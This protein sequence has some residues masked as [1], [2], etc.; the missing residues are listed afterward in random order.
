MVAHYPGTTVSLTT[1]RF[2]FKR[3]F[4]GRFATGSLQSKA[5]N[6]RG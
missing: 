2:V 5:A 3:P 6:A 1:D 4:V